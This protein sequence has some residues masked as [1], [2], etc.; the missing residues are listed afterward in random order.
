MA[1]R[2]DGT[3]FE[4][5]NCDM[6]CPCTWSAFAAA[7]T[8][9]RCLVTL[10]YHVDS[11]EVDGVDVSGLT[12]ALVVDAPQHMA[13]GGWRVGVCLD[14]KATDEQA[15]K[16]GQVVSG[17]LGGPPSALTPLLGEM[18][19]IERVPIE[20][21]SEGGTHSARLGKLAE[22]DVADLHVAEMAEPVQL[23]NVFHPSNTTLTLSPPKRANVDAFGIKYV[24]VSGF[25]A[26]FS[27][28]A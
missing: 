10:V 3:Y 16:L 21:R 11:G 2:M 7:A 25:S 28:S 15:D 22:I 18:L 27:W 13:E 20:Y 17:G 8:H 1:W 6:L 24:G 9:D 12:F 19:G 5:C 4:S 23:T 26:P 14:E